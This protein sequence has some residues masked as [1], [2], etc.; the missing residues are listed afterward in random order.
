MLANITPISFK[1]TLD[2]LKQ[3]STFYKENT[4]QARRNLRS[5]IEKQSFEIN[6]NFLSSF[7]EVKDSFDSVYKDIMEINKQ[8]QD[9][10]TRVQNTKTQTRQLLDQTSTLQK[11]G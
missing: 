6:E 2:A 9:M 1:E 10:T 5:Q 4:I 3:L 8:L 7:R 11:D